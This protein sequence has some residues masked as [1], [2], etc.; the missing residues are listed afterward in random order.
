LRCLV[1]RPGCNRGQQ[2][3]EHDLH[4][5][6]LGQSAF[7][8]RK[9][10]REAKAGSTLLLLSL[11]CFPK[12]CSRMYFFPDRPVEDGETG[13]QRPPETTGSGSTRHLLNDQREAKADRPLTKAQPVKLAPM[14]TQ[15]FGSSH[16]TFLFCGPWRIG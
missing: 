1:L 10:G 15:P 3:G 9:D 6:A 11:R 12:I 7:P 14:G 8:K 4:R 2:H 16:Q 5:D 13:P